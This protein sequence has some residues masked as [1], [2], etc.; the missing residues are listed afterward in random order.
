[1]SE[2]RDLRAGTADMSSAASGRD[3]NGADTGSGADTG[4]G[5]GTASSADTGSGT[6]ATLQLAPLSSINSAVGNPGRPHSG[7]E[8]QALP[9]WATAAC[10]LALA[11]LTFAAYSN[12]IF[13]FF[14][15]DDFGLIIWLKAATVH[16][17]ALLK[18]FQG[19]WLSSPS[20]QFYRPL[21][22]VT[23]LIDYFFYG[24]NSTGYHVTNI[25]FLISTSICLYFIVARL[26]P[27]SVG[28]KL[29]P[30]LAATLFALYPLHSETV[31]WI[32]GRV[33]GVCIAF[34][35]ASVM[36]YM[37]WRCERTKWAAGAS[38]LCMALALFA[39]EMGIMIPAT[40]VAYEM[41]VGQA[42]TGRGI[43]GKAK[44]AAKQTW[45]FWLLL[46][47]YFVLR[48]VT[49]GTFVG[50]YDDS[51]FLSAGWN[52][53]SYK[54]SQGLRNLLVPANRELMG[55]RNPLTIIWQ[56][57]LAPA[58][59]LLLFS[60]R[61]HPL[62]NAS[63]FCFSWMLLSLAPVYK[64]FSISDILQN[65]RY[66]YLASAPLCCLLTLGFAY[67]LQLLQ[68]RWR[69]VASNQGLAGA[70]DRPALARTAFGAVA[71]VL[72]TMFTTAGLMLHRNNEAWAEAGRTANAIVAQLRRFYDETPGD[73]Q[74][75]VLNLPDHLKGAYICRNAFEG[76]TQT[77]ELS[78]DIKNC[79]MF[80]QFDRLRPVGFIKDSL[81]REGD[82]LP[83][84]AWN[85]ETKTLN[86]VKL[87]ARL[88]EAKPSLNL[89]AKTLAE[90]IK[91][92]GTTY[93]ATV[94]Q[95]W[96]GGLSG[97]AGST[98]GAVHGSVAVAVPASVPITTITQK[99]PGKRAEIDIP[100]AGTQPC[101]PLDFI[102]VELEPV[103]MP[104]EPVVDLEFSNDLIPQSTNDDLIRAFLESP[105]PGRA[106]T[107]L[108]SMRNH[109]T[110]ILGGNLH[111]LRLRLPRGTS[112]RLH[113]IKAV[114]AAAIMPRLTV[115]NSDWAGTKGF[116]RLD[117]Q[118]PEV[119]VSYDATNLPN[120]AG[121]EMEVTSRNGI[122][123]WPNPSN[124]TDRVMS[125]HA[126]ARG[127]FTLKR[128]DF[129]DIGLFALRCRAVDKKGTRIGVTSDHFVVFMP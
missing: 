89:D 87:D 128:S 60:L 23:L 88:L 59:V 70:A 29:W 4:R 129:P 25:L 57:C 5:A 75:M 36:F 102:A 58:A 124:E 49:L 101:F 15:G 110:W 51:P 115:P 66:G 120:A 17:E 117:T 77:P 2:G 93:S 111:K 107:V 19:P 121:I 28:L 112:Y 18:D 68:S 97:G 1:M 35:M 9:A 39:K 81:A 53:I 85:Q 16:I 3:G 109:P 74:V 46:V 30:A 50:G 98:A 82:R 80:N 44:V 113:S 65:S 79:S 126:G 106:Q 84:L 108:F 99:K 47:G 12:V 69:S 27:R 41:T 122:F 37:R 62:R 11:G 10:L 52:A 45:A 55:A 118:N 90:T 105:Q 67:V 103:R 61:K 104:N 94:S 116:V 13:N 32:I 56:V 73:P 21:I 33:D 92:E 38:F 31:S 114:Q 42:G 78:R 22:S 91:P 100:I 14:L 26:T 48:R 123:E 64:L 20:A 8:T 72:A 95:I 40:L 71:L 83:I 86:R 63:L 127:T 119:S 125:K 96:G 24:F 6:I 54:W 76:M 43:V 7:E 34:Y